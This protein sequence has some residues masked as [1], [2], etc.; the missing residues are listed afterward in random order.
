MLNMYDDMAASARSIAV[1]QRLRTAPIIYL[2]NFCNGWNILQ[3]D[4]AKLTSYS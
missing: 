2:D 3:L 1:C 4:V